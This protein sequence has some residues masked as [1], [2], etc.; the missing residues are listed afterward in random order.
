MGNWSFRIGLVL[1]IFLAF[2]NLI[3][4]GDLKF[5]YIGRLVEENGQPVSGPIEL[6]FSYFT[7]EDGPAGIGS[8]ETFTEVA[9]SDG[10]FQVELALN[11][12]VWTLLRTSVGN[13]PWI[14][15]SNVT[16]GKTYPR[17]Q[18]SAVPLALAIPVDG[19]TIGWNQSGA[20]E[21]LESASVDRV[22]GQSVLFKDA[23][24]TNGVT[25][26]S[27]S[28]LKMAKSDSDLGLDFINR[29]RPVSFYWKDGD[30][31]LH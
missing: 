15:V 6:Q 17:Q 10:V 2:S 22:G 14:E 19:T 25:T 9:L 4:A 12:Q 11:Q 7:T 26:T 23:Y 3:W 28:R 1:L 21:I 30:R 18:L 13:P 31:N 27:D 16:N 5:T 8:P 20:L 29:L 24:V